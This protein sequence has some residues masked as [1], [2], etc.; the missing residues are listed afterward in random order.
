M[1]CHVNTLS[2]MKDE[3]HAFGLHGVSHDHNLLC[4][5][6]CIIG[7]EDCSSEIIR[8]NW[9]CCINQLPYGSNPYDSC[10]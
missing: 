4:F 3:G 1:S 2:R 7:N 5:R 9:P 8:N 6:K 10:I